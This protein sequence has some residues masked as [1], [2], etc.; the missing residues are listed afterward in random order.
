M[1]QIANLFA[2]WGL[3]VWLI[4]IGTFILTQLVKI[5]VKKLAVSKLGEDEK[6]KITK[7][8]VFLPVLFAFIGALIDCWIRAGF[9][10]APFVEG[11]DWTRVFK[12]AVTAV[13][14]PAFAFSVF[15]N[16]QASHDIDVMND[17]KSGSREAQEAKRQAELE[18]AKA[19]AIANADA[20]A[21][22]KVE[23]QQLALAEKQ[24]KLELARQKEL[25]RINKELEA[26]NAKKTSISAVES[27]TAPNKAESVVH[28]EETHFKEIR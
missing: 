22:A 14:L 21:K 16:F 7:W 28:A 19:N 11:F 18:V 27:Y 8:I 9:W 12:L 23:K 25:D 10:E 24:K 5:P 6:K 17:L 4:A 13:G 15:E 3:S 26:L 20:K 2:E 1:D